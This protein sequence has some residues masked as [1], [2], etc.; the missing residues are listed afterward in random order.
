MANHLSI[1]QVSIGLTPRPGH[2][3]DRGCSPTTVLLTTHV[4]AFQAPGPGSRP[5]WSRE[6]GTARGTQDLD[7]GRWRPRVRSPTRPP[8]AQAALHRGWV[9]WTGWRGPLGPHP[10]PLMPNWPASLSRWLIAH[11]ATLGP[12]RAQVKGQRSPAGQLEERVTRSR[13]LRAGPPASSFTAVLQPANSLLLENAGRGLR[14]RP[15]G[16]DQA[17]AGR[18]LTSGP[19]VHPAAQLYLD[20]SPR[21]RERHPASTP[22]LPLWGLSGWLRE[23]SL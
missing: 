7:G 18:S 21:T 6:A 14:L 22:L 20:S 8:V 3:R 10:R 19:L 16:L 13:C 1:I 15:A 5:S 2:P 4:W 9:H 17:P 12:P 23:L 11:L